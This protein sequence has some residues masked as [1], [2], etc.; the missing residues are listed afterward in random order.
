[1]GSEP[2]ADSKKASNSKDDSK[3][4]TSPPGRLG[5]DSPDDGPVPAPKPKAEPEP[6]A[7]PL[8]MESSKPLDTDSSRPELDLT[9]TV[10][11]TPDEGVASKEQLPAGLSVGRKKLAE[12]A[13]AGAKLRARVE[14][15]VIVKIEVVGSG[16]R[17]TEG[18]GR[19]VD[20]ADGWLELRVEP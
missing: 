13:G 19:G 15:K 5:G 18:V 1:M 10:T 20:L 2:F 14:K 6:K 8:D 7:E 17:C 9:S 16:K 4:P 11:F 12:C 3:H